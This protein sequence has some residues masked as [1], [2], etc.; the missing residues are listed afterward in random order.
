M[1]DTAK[2]FSALLGVVDENEQYYTEAMLERESG[3]FV[4]ALLLTKKLVTPEEV[5]A[6][7]KQWIEVRNKQLIDELK[8]K[9]KPNKEQEA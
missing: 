4:I 7:K 3:T 8:G 9:A 2:L 6:F 5:S 1:N